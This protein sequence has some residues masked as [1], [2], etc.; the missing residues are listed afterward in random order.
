[1]RFA[2]IAIASATV[3]L[4]FSCVLRVRGQAVRLAIVPQYLHKYSMYIH[5]ILVVMLV[6]HYIHLL[7]YF[8]FEFLLSLIALGWTSR[9]FIS[10]VVVASKAAQ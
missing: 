10:A 2:N 5:D 8:G 7:L 3:G 6:R 1:M 4:Y 9:I